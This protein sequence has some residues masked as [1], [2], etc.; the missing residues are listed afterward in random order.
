MPNK[1][2]NAYG[3]TVLCP[4]KNDS[5]D[6]QSY[7]AIVRRKLRELPLDEE[8]PLAAV[9]ETYLCRMFVLDD[10]FYEGDPAG[11]DHLKSKYLVL[12]V[13]LHGERDAWLRA[14]WTH[15]QDCIQ[16]LWK[17]CIAFQDVRSADDWV[18]YIGRCQ[19]DTTFYFMGST[20][21]P[22][23][24]QLKA[25]Y[26]KQELAHFALE[27]QGVK[28]PAALQRSF[29][30]FLARVQPDNLSGPTWR[31]GASSLETAVVGGRT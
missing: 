31:A 10:V 29:Q 19:V 8:S 27:H 4:L 23:A 18:A 20:D 14:M 26:L 12:V 7:A 1:N 11:E 15:A 5:E 17:Y 22:L 25:L 24:E 28:D 6:D 21:E 9:P 3:L 13:E 16:K 30:D 2:G